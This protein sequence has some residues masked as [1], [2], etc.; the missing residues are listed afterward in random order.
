MSIDDFDVK[1]G[2]VDLALL[3]SASASGVGAASDADPVPWDQR[4]HRSFESWKPTAST[5][6]PIM[7]V[8]CKTPS[9]IGMEKSCAKIF[10]LGMYSN[11]PECGVYLVGRSPTGNGWKLP[12]TGEEHQLNCKAVETAG[13]DEL[14]TIV[15]GLVDDGILFLPRGIKHADDHGVLIPAS[16]DG[17]PMSDEVLTA[18]L[19]SFAATNLPCD[20]LRSELWTDASKYWPIKEAEVTIQKFLLIALRAVFKNY[21]ILSETKV[22]PGRID[23]L[24]LPGSSKEAGKVVLELKAIRQYG[25]TGIAVS[26]STTIAHLVGGV[27]Q[28][29]TYFQDATNKYICTYDMRRDMLDEVFV[30]ARVDCVT[31]NVKLRPYKVYPN[32]TS[33]RHAVLASMDCEGK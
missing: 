13:L 4:W 17:S 18:E 32:A 24:I 25:S 31:N 14:P 16:H 19:D 15:V 12:A 2:G 21:V 22:A 3:D 26:S 5:P 28:A 23:I 10:Q 8:F 1:F 11:R 29:T 20:E 9:V 27:V 7:L 30:Q 6:A 33:V